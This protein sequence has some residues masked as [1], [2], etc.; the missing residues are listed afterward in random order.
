MARKVRDAALETRR[1]R[2]KLSVGQRYWTGIREG[3][4]LGY[5]RGSQGVGSWSVRLLLADGRYMLRGIGDSDDQSSADGVSV[6]NYVQAKTKATTVGQ[7]LKHAEGTLLTPEALAD[8]A[9][10]YLAWF[11]SKKNSGAPLVIPAGL[12]DRRLG[13]LTLKEL[14]AWIQSQHP[15]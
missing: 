1:E 11:K 4:A 13:S 3:L 8:I 14:N 10:Q 15:L 5:R 6:L 7:Q 9:E 12:E 2:L